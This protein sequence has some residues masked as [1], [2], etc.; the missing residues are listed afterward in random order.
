[1]HNISIIT[2]FA[3]KHNKLNTYLLKTFLDL[4]DIF[5]HTRCNLLI[6]CPKAWSTFHELYPWIPA[7]TTHW[8]SSVECT[9]SLPMGGSGTAWKLHT[10]NWQ[11]CGVLIQ[12][13]WSFFVQSHNTRKK[14]TSFCW[15][16]GFFKEGKAQTMPGGS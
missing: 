11:L 8:L 1:M 10:R 6:F 12:K 5:Y 13:Q 16:W 2:T 7:C 4:V 9:T 15:N 3:T 14:V